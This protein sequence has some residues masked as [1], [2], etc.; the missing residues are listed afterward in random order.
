MLFRSE[1]YSSNPSLPSGEIR[2]IISDTGIG[3][4]QEETE[5]VFERFYRTEESRAIDAEGVGLGL[6]IVKWI[7]EVHGGKIALQS[8]PGVGSTFTISLPSCQTPAEEKNSVGQ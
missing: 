4:P 8:A 7:V 5:H 1:R 3:I 6:A 2:L